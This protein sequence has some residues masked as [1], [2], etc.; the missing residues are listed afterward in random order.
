MPAPGYDLFRG[1]EDTI[2]KVQEKYA[3]WF[4]GR[5]TVLDIG[6]GRGEFLKILRSRSIPALGIDLDLKMVE[7]CVKADLE[8]FHADPFSFLQNKTGA[9]GGIF[10]SHVVE[11]LEG[12]EAV[13]LLDLAYGALWQGGRIVVITPNPE[14]L[15]VI[16]RTFWLDLSHRRPYPLELLKGL[17]AERGFDVLATGEDFDTIPGRSMK[18]AGGAIRLTRTLFPSRL[19][20]PFLAAKDVFVAAEKP[21]N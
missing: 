1:D 18:I 20:K 5:G 19:C 9:F 7:Q 17:L 14:N 8:V 4:E 11:H 3:S 15:D 2:T 21:G 6:C 13:K 12:E 16:S 10:L